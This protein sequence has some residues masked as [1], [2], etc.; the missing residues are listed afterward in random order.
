MKGKSLEKFRVMLKDYLDSLVLKDL[1]AY[2]RYVGVSNSTE[3]KKSKLIDEI[4]GVLV[5]DI[6]PQKPSTRGAPV[7]NDFVDPKIE[8]DIARIRKACENAATMKGLPAFGDIV[9]DLGELYSPD[10]QALKFE[11]PLAEA[12]RQASYVYRGQVQ[13]FNGIAC[14]LPTDC[15]EENSQRIY[16]PKEL[17]DTHDLRE[18]DIISCHACKGENALIVCE[19]LS[20]NDSFEPLPCRLQFERAEVGFPT[21]PIRFLGEGVA[22]T[23]TDKYFEWVTPVLKGQRGLLIASPKAG[24]TTMLY[25]M[26]KTLQQTDNTILPLVLLVDQSPEVVGAFRSAMY[27]ENVICSTY[28]DDADKQVFTAEFLLKRAKRMA[29]TGRDVV[30]FVDGFNALARAY[31]ETE[32]SDGGKVLEGGLES[33]TLHYLK[34]FFGAARRLRKGGSLTVIG[35]L[36]CDT[37]NPSDD[38][39]V[40]QLTTLANLEIRLDETRSLKRSYPAIDALNSRVSLGGFDMQTTD[41]FLQAEFLPRFG[42]EGLLSLLSQAK[43]IEELY[44]LARQ[45]L[46]Q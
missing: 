12:A 7:K 14:L 11:S 22:P 33:K 29:E 16:L 10:G 9:N 15:I 35:T 6:P 19:V 32:E 44:A 24:K 34:K 26:V 37:G 43:S 13:T 5:G 20:V 45:K 25:N 36:S 42:S 40:Q 23:V 2:G 27:F 3:K 41:T 28:E 39:L 46:E 17:I 21:T 18:G 31:N 1:R 8:E 4:I 38:L 30:L